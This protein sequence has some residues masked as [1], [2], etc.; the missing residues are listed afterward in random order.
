[1][2]LKSYTLRKRKKIAYALSKKLNQICV[3][4]STSWKT[5]LAEKVKI[6][7]YFD[8]EYVKIKEKI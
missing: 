4:S 7:A 8:Q 6:V 1:M 5:N 3:I 2:F